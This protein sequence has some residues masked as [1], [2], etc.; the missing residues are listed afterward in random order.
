MI[1]ISGLFAFSWTTSVLMN[2]VAQVNADRD[3]AARSGGRLTPPALF[4][5]RE[6]D[7]AA[8]R[9]DLDRVA[10]REAAGEDL[11]RQRVLDL[12]LD[13]ALQRPRAVDRVEAGLRD[14]RRAPRR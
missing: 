9:V 4:S 8:V 13:R 6:R 10:R 5:L 12:L 2:I 11:L 14:L 3:A 7:L 1:A